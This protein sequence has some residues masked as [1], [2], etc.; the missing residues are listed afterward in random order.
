MSK[1]HQIALTLVEGVGPRIAKTLIAHCGGAEEVFNASRK[2]L[3][4]IPG[5]PQKII[6]GLNKKEVFERAEKEIKFCEKHH[7]KIHYFKDE[8]YPYRLERCEDGPVILYQSGDTNL[9]QQRTIGIV[10]SRNA[11]LYGEFFTQKICK[12]LVVHNPLIISGMAYGIDHFAHK[13]ALENRLL[14]VG[15]MAHGLDRIYPSIH[16]KT[17]DKMLEEGGGL[18]SEFMSETNPD[19]EN[20]PKRNRIIAGMSDAVLVIEAKAGGGALITAKL[21]NDYN[22]D[23]FALPGRWNDDLS[24]GCNNLIKQNLAN[25]LTGIRDIEYIMDWSTDAKVKPAT[26]L[27]MFQNLNDTERAVVT[28]LQSQGKPVPIDLISYKLALPINKV[29]TSLITLELSGL[30]SGLP[31]KMYTLV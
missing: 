14:T 2:T 23:V 21:A 17:V 26:Q 8:S 11:T 10:G 16:K 31:G 7:I 15:A 9:N 18:V 1:I 20:F 24:M 22:R 6:S 29:S 5:V 25:V 13:A 19:R 27:S 4:K 28:L 3:G 30:V 12:E